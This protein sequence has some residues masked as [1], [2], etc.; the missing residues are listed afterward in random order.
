MSHHTCKALNFV[1]TWVNAIPVW[2]LRTCKNDANVAVDAVNRVLCDNY[3]QLKTHT[4]GDYL[5]CQRK[6]TLNLEET[7]DNC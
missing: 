7:F 1:N 2:F 3:Q 4:N 6:C 5:K